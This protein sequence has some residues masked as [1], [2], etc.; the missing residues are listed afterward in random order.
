MTHSKSE[1]AA[2]S[3]SPED[4]IAN[5]HKLMDDV[6][7][8]VSRPGEAAHSLAGGRLDELQERLSGAADKVRG[9]YKTA[10]RKV[11]AGASQADETIRSH[12]YQALAI[13]LGIGVLLGAVIRR[14]N[15]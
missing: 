3:P 14:R 8:I 1:A 7:A 11:A 2:T 9:M 13:A 12:P 4:L 6:E 15:D 5:I 10:K